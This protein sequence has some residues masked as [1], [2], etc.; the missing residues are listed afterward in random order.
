MKK[1]TKIDDTNDCLGI[2]NLIN[3]LNHDDFIKLKKLLLQSDLKYDEYIKYLIH[4]DINNTDNSDS[5]IIDFYRKIG[6][7]ISYS[8]NPKYKKH[9]DRV[10]EFEKKYH[11]GR[12]IENDDMFF[13]CMTMET[14]DKSNY[15]QVILVHI[16]EFFSIYE[17]DYENYHKQRDGG[18]PLIRRKEK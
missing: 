1:T 2:K 10:K 5:I 7:Q 16:E 12:K 4:C 13:T 17:I 8:H 14:D 3:I 6:K 11:S 18:L 15:F 9:I